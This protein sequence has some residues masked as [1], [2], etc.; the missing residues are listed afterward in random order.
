MWIDKLKFEN[1][2]VILFQSLSMYEQN[3]FKNTWK[4]MEEKTKFSKILPNYQIITACRIKL[5]VQKM[6]INEKLTMIGLILI[7]KIIISS[8]Q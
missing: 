3:T 8:L 1:I 7:S 6:T 5:W 2:S 4:K